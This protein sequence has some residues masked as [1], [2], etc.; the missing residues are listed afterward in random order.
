MKV[1]KEG[2]IRL[3]KG[4]IRIGNFF[5]RDEGENEHIRLTDLNSCFTLRVWK[6]MPLGIW[7]D[8]MLKMGEGGLDSIKAYIAMMWTTFSVAPDNDF[9]KD[10]LDASDANF[11]RH[12][13][14]YNSNT[15][16]TEKED[17]SAL[18]EVEGMS[19][20]EEEVKDANVYGEN[21]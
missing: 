2:K 12:P 3:E 15:D 14:W 7:L 11:K 4:E 6:R 20:L 21:G 18:E 19:Q 16:A 5:V 9:V 1:N 10:L 8:N 13:E 17:A